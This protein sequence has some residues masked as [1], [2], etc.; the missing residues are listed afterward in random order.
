LG[1][2]KIRCA[3]ILAESRVEKHQES[4]SINRRGKNPSAKRAVEDSEFIGGGGPGKSLGRGKSA[5]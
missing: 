4:R 1:I 5:L 2:E 3:A